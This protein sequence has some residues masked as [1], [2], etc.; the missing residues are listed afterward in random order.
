MATPRPRSVCIAVP[1]PRAVVE[2]C[3]I[4][5]ACGQLPDN[6]GTPPQLNVTVDLDALRG[7]VAVG[8][9]HTG[10]LLSPEATRRLACD[11]LILPVLLNGASIPIDIG[12]ARRTFASAARQAVILRDG[13]CAFLGCDRPPRW[14][15]V[16]HVISWLAGGPTDRDNGVALCSYHHRLIHHSNWHIQFGKDKRPEFIPP[17]HIDPTQRARRNPYHLR[18]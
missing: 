7:N 3:R 12:R 6:G 1:C 10:G 13:G 5:L 4:A 18:T 15:Q 17:A 14:C 11:A 9:L 16:H 8:Q 2:V